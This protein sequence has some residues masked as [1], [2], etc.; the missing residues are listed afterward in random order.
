[1][2]IKRESWSSTLTI[3][4]ESNVVLK[5]DMQFRLL[6]VEQAKLVVGVCLGQRNQGGW[7]KSLREIGLKRLSSWVGPIGATS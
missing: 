6:D 5:P 1:M 4:E 3:G 7:S 2:S